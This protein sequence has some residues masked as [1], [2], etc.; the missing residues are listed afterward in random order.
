MREILIEIAILA[1][2][3][4]VAWNVF[5]LLDPVWGTSYLIVLGLVA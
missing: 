4:F 5:G 2:T 3:G 1:A